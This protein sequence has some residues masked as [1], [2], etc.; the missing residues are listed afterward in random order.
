LK[1]TIM[2]TSVKQTT[3][4]LSNSTD[5]IEL[6]RLLTAVQADLTALRTSFTT[7]TAK[8][9]ADAGVTDANYAATCDP[10][11]LETAALTEFFSAGLDPRTA[12]LTTRI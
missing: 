12:G 10:A 5:G 11:A 6:A 7:L 3:N 1:E 2:S 4:A 8:L 9:D